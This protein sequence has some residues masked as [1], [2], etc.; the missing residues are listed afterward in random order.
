MP[1]ES[2]R[3]RRFM[4]AELGRLRSG[5]ATETGMSESQLEDFASSEGLYEQKMK[6]KKAPKVVTSSNTDHTLV[7]AMRAITN[8]I[9]IIEKAAPRSSG[10]PTGGQ[11]AS[12]AYRRNQENWQRSG[13]PKSKPPPRRGGPQAGRDLSREV[14]IEA[15]RLLKDNRYISISPAEIAETLG[16]NKRTVGIY[17]KQHKLSDAARAN[18]RNT[19]ILRQVD[20]QRPYAQIAE[21]MGLRVAQIKK[22]VQR[23]KRKAQE[24]QDRYDAEQAAQAETPQVEPKVVEDSPS[25]EPREER[26]PSYDV[27]RE[28]QGLQPLRN[29]R[30]IEETPVENT[31]E[32]NFSNVQSAY[33]EKQFMT[34]QSERLTSE[35]LLP[36]M[37]SKGNFISNKSIPFTPD[38]QEVLATAFNAIDSFIKQQENAY[39]PTKGQRRED[40]RRKARKMGVSGRG[41]KETQ[42]II[43]RKGR[44]GSG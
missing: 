38:K 15:K 30:K 40:K 3:Q 8:F 18:E 25:V 37:D 21:E 2:E 34:P 24:R 20:L 7:K 44:K 14:L 35:E 43:G 12:A 1:A 33:Q 29:T 19:K 36:S 39:P 42:Q 4:G 11:R 41:V 27:F 22:L 28:Q 6:T 5:E 17:L 26:P 16:I 13:S 10:K 23:T 32:G 31:N 9:G